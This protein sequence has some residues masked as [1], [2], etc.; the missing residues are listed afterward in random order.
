MKLKHLI[1]IALIGLLVIFSACSDDAD[2]NVVGTDTE[3]FEAKSSPYLICANRNPGGVG[4]DFEYDS[5]RGGA[6]FMDSLSVIDFTADA[7]IRTIK[8][9]KPDGTL[10]G[11]PFFKLADN[12]QAINYSSIDTNCVGYTAFQNLTEANLQSFTYQSDDVGFDLDALP[13]GNTGKHYKSDLENEYKKLVIGLRFKSTANNNV[14]GDELVWVIKTSEG[15][16]IKMIVTDFP[17]DPAPTSTGYI[18]VEWDFL[19]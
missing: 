12:V 16:Q 6:N 7:I 14:E 19:D 2:N 10:A 13:T 9:E 3:I 1:S 17:A 5:N 11:M 4:F 15:R 18:A 8:G